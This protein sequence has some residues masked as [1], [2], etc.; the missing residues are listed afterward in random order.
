M[1]RCEGFG[2]DQNKKRL[3]KGGDD[4]RNVKRG[5]PG[6]GKPVYKIKIALGRRRNAVKL[7]KGGGGKDSTQKNVGSQHPFQVILHEGGQAQEKNL[8]RTRKKT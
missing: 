7:R 1:L 5:M 8:R 6:L 3:L 4:Y 2:H